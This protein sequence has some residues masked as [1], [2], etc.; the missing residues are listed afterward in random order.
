MANIKKFDM[1]D[2]LSAEINI[3]VEKGFFGL[4]TRYVYTPTG[5][6][7]VGFTRDFTPEMGEKM[8]RVL[9]TTEK[10]LAHAISQAGDIRT[11]PIGHW[12]LEACISEDHRFAAVQLFRFIDFKN[13]PATEIRIYEGEAA[14]QI[15]AVLK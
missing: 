4:T 9:N 5:S 6:Q 2:A 1:A 15:A 12:H 10:D 14:A 13:T 7:L 11:T 3:S 8:E